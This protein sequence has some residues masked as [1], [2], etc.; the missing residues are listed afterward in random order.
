MVYTQ[1]FQVRDY[2]CRIV[3]PELTIQLDAVSG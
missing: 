3:E 2:L 1:L